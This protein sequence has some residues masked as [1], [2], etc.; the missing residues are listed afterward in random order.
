MM[1]QSSHQVLVDCSSLCAVDRANLQAQSVLKALFAR[2]DLLVVFHP[3]FSILDG[4]RTSDCI[5]KG[6]AAPQPKME[7]Y[8]Q[9]S[10]GSVH[11]WEVVLDYAPGEDNQTCNTGNK[12][13]H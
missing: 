5:E 6:A 3:G 7:I 1:E 2:I 10:G 11:I 9:L 4:K 13:D 8:R 12:H